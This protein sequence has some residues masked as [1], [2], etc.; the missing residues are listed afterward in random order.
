MACTA[1]SWNVCGIEVA[2]LEA[3]LDALAHQVDW[4]FIGLQEF[5]KQKVKRLETMVRGHRLIHGIAEGGRRFPALVLH[6][7]W[8]AARCRIRR[9]AHMIAV[10]VGSK[11]FASI[12]MPHSGAADEVFEAACDEVIENIKQLRGGV[13]IPLVLAMDLN[14]EFDREVLPWIGGHPGGSFTPRAEIAI[15]FLGELGCSLVNTFV[16][17]EASRPGFEGTN[18]RATAIDHIAATL[19]CTPKQVAILQSIRFATSTDHLPICATIV[20][21]NDHR[22]DSGNG[23]MA[24]TM[25]SPASSRISKGT[26]L[27][28]R[29]SDTQDR[30]AARD[31]NRLAYATALDGGGGETIRRDPAALDKVH[32]HLAE[33]V[34]GSG[35]FRIGRCRAAEYLVKAERDGLA[36]L[37]REM[38]VA[39]RQSREAWK[40]ASK[41]V[42]RERRRLGRVKTARLLEAQATG[43]DWTWNKER[44]QKYCDAE[45]LADGDELT[46]ERGDW[47]QLASDT[48]AQLYEAPEDEQANVETWM[49]VTRDALDSGGMTYDISTEEGRGGMMEW[50][51]RHLPADVWA[52]QARHHG[53]LALFT[54]GSAANV[55]LP[56]EPPKKRLRRDCDE[57]QAPSRKRKRTR[58]EF[59][60]QTCQTFSPLEE[61]PAMSAGWGFAAVLRC[62]TCPLAFPGRHP[63][64]TLL[65][66]ACGKVVCDATD[67][68][69][70]GAEAETNGSAEVV[71]I[72]KALSWNASEA[73]DVPGTVVRYGSVYAASAIT[74]SINT[75]SNQKAVEWAQAALENLAN[76]L[77]VSF[78]HVSAHS[79][80]DW[81]DLADS[82]ASRGEKGE[83]SVTYY[84]AFHDRKSS[85]SAGL[86]ECVTNPIHLLS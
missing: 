65:A 56:A 78:L 4:D 38:E 45:T 21:G 82:L 80:N 67:A 9:T 28:T 10:S 22:N 17:L 69:F 42:W 41:K 32:E 77:P 66:T 58:A 31:L 46:Y 8:H 36:G 50:I 71:A 26:A 40:V 68:R 7:R 33:A 16:P 74:G 3:V 18:V 54:D 11:I 53:H 14:V 79:D 15:R 57:R 34:R 49:K 52:P 27:L 24:A 81:N 37:V 2:T 59:A 5:S 35:A 70:A 84:D 39:G 1:I 48:L 75:V 83:E 6:R 55:T 23:E 61:Q 30:A 12:H 64:D 51:S 20:A 72:T 47:G 76:V 73:D 86:A 29:H 60:N 85:H 19:P 25:G 44:R 62:S 63:G 43:Q 13:N